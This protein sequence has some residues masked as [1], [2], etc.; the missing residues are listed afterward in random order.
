MQQVAFHAQFNV[1]VY[2]ACNPDIMDP[3]STRNTSVD[4]FSVGS[5]S[6]QEKLP[7]RGKNHSVLL[8]HN[9]TTITKLACAQEK[10]TIKYAT[11]VENANGSYSIHKGIF[12][13]NFIKHLESTATLN[14]QDFGKSFQNF[15]AQ[16]S[17]G[18]HI[19]WS[20]PQTSPFR[21]HIISLLCSWGKDCANSL[22]WR[23]CKQYVLQLTA[24]FT[25]TRG[26]L[27][28]SATYQGRHGH[29][30][31]N[32]FWIKPK[33]EKPETLMIGILSTFEHIV[34]AIAN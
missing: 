20:V 28:I 24:L 16:K 23:K 1:S 33:R 22:F 6:H 15:V 27:S 17:N 5:W 10:L 18:T 7:Y 14:V 21:T 29:C 2:K 34:A 32:L 4:N 8:E 9:S 30:P 25:S 3:G 13:S 11:L 19:L 26:E 12:I 31:T